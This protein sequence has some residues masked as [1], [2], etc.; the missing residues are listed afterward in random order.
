[1]I[2]GRALA[3]NGK[4]QNP[5]LGAT[6]ITGIS[7]ATKICTECPKL[8]LPIHI[9]P[10]PD[11]TCTQGAFVAT[12][13]V[14]EPLYIPCPCFDD[15]APTDQ[16]QTV[17]GQVDV[18]VCPK[19]SRT[20]RSTRRQTPEDSEYDDAFFNSTSQLEARSTALCYSDRKV[21]VLHNS[22]SRR[23]DKAL[24][25]KCSGFGTY[26]MTKLKASPKNI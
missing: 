2:L 26:R 3:P 16:V 8:L 23:I 25:K 5:T 6:R 9:M 10:Q 22:V 13:E 24:R 12:E 14:G 17:S 20:I 4:S 1:M 7:R 18:R 11:L 21:V 19:N 15:Q